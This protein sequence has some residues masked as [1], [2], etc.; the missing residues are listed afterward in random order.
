M[1]CLQVCGCAN[2]GS[3]DLTSAGIFTSNPTVLVNGS[4]SYQLTDTWRVSVEVLNILDRRDHDIDYAYESRVTPTAASIFEDVFHPVEPI[5]VRGGFMALMAT[6]PER[7]PQT[8]EDV[9]EKKSGC[10]S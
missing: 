6:K 2:F 1:D 8:S 9:P 4:A 7:N 3:R 10:G 5:Q